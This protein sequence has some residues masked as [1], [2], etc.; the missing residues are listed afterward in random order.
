MKTTMT[1]LI[2]AVT[3]AVLAII[4]ILLVM[5][6]MMINE[7]QSPFDLDETIEH[8]KAAASEEGWVISGVADLAASVKKHGGYD[9]PATRLINLCQ[10]G[11][12]HKILSEDGNKK[13]SVFMPCTISVYQKTDG[14]I[15]LAT[16]NAGLLGKMFGGTVAEV[17]GETVAKQQQK[18]ISFLH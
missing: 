2:A 10:A 1:A 17:M 7:Y 12:A 13:I 5:P 15:Y 4:L 8:I 16:M 14:K 6:S 9:L 3:G 18:F 11:H